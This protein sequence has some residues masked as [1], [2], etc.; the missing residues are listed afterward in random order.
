MA[1]VNII[2]FLSL[3][4]I[5]FLWIF[6]FIPSFNS[7]ATLRH[8]ILS[9]LK[10]FL[11]VFMCAYSLPKH[12]QPRKTGNDNECRLSNLISKWTKVLQLYRYE[13]H[14]FR[15][16]KGSAFLSWS[17]IYICWSIVTRIFIGLSFISKYKSGN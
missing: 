15:V 8:F 1:I 16:L 12:I 13:D 2:H 14:L 5:V 6:L 7:I 17:A 9:F 4:L 3:V 11:Q 10:T